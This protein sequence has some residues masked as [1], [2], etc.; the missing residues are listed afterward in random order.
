MERPKEDPLLHSA[1]REALIVFGVWLAAMVYTVTYCAWRGYGRSIED[2]TYVCGFPDWVFWGIVAP[3]CACTLVSLWFAYHVMTDDPL[4]DEVPD[5][6]DAVDAV[7]PNGP[8]AGKPGG[9]SGRDG[10]SHSS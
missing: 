9:Q 6:F 1:R 2:L 7:F 4:G 8:S 3:W 10:A 5:T